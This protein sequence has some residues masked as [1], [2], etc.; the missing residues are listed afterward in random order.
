MPG[1]QVGD[2]ELVDVL[3]AGAY[4]E[5]QG[6]REVTGHFLPEEP[7]GVDFR[8]SHARIV[9]AR[10]NLKPTYMSPELAERRDEAT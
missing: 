1:G 2:A 4:R 3:V 5:C 6:G 8:P 9:R 10:V 7:Y